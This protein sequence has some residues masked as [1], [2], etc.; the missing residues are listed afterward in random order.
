MCLCSKSKGSCKTY[1]DTCHTSDKGKGRGSSALA[2]SPA[3]RSQPSKK[4]SSTATSQPQKKHKVSL[5]YTK[6]K[7]SSATAAVAAMDEEHEEL[8][9]ESLTPEPC[10]NNQPAFSNSTDKNTPTGFTED[11]Q[12]DIEHIMSAAVMF[13]VEIPARF[14]EDVTL[15]PG[16]RPG[17][18]IC[19]PVERNCSELYTEKIDSDKRDTSE[20]EVRL[21]KYKL[22]SVTHASENHQLI[23][24][25][26]ITDPVWRSQRAEKESSG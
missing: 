13:P 8:T 7:P 4:G 2:S 22:K 26:M 1:I 20:L 9:P 23:Q 18:L 21:H 15:G 3:P 17:L 11:P 25:V 6:H 14:T 10:S 16:P 19:S 12:G 24:I 5:Y